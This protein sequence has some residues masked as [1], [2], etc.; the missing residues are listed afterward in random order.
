MEIKTELSLRYRIDSGLKG[1]GRKIPIIKAIIWTQ[2]Q[3]KTSEINADVLKVG[4][5]TR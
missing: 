2:T 4:K 5:P 1:E 3:Y